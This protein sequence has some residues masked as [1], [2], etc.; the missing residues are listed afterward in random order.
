MTEAQSIK[1][2]AIIDL[3]WDL[4]QEEDINKMF[5]MGRKLSKMKSDLR[6]DMG[7]AEYDHFIEMGRRMFKSVE[8]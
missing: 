6:D 2:R 1:L 8:E 7:H 4:K 3:N 5:E